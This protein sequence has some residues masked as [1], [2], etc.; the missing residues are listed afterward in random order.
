MKILRTI[1]TLC[2]AALLFSGCQDEEMIKQSGVKEGIPVTIDLTFS[3][4]IPEQEH[5]GTRTIT[6]PE[7][8]VNDLYVLIFN[9]NTGVLKGNV[10]S[11]DFTELGDG[12]KEIQ[13]DG[14]T[15]LQGTLSQIKTTTGESVIYAI[16]NVNNPP[17]EYNIT[18][19]V[20][21][22]ITNVQT[23][24]DLEKIVVKLRD[25]NA[26]AVDRIYETRY[27]MS[28]SLA[29]NIDENGIS[30]SD[31]DIPLLRTDSYITF[32]IDNKVEGTK[33]TSF[34]LLS[35]RIYNIPVGTS[36][37]SLDDKNY[38]DGVSD[39][40]ANYWNFVEAEQTGGNTF[41]FYLPEN[42]KQAKESFTDYASRD[43][44]NKNSDGTNGSFKYAPDY[45]T[46]VVLHGIYEGTASTTQ[47]IP[48]VENEENA[49]V[50]ASVDYI[51]HLGNF[52][53]YVTDFS[54]KRN[55]HYTYTIHV[56]GVDD[57]VVEVETSGDENPQEPEPGAEGDVFFR[58]GIFYNLDCH[59]E[60]VLMEFTAQEIQNVGAQADKYIQY[61]IS[62]PFGDKEDKH[63]LH[64]VLNKRAG[65]LMP[66][67][68]DEACKFADEAEN[69]IYTTNSVTVMSLDG[70]MTALNDILIKNS[71]SDYANNSGGIS[72]TCFVNEYVYDDKSWAEYV[73]Q[74][75]REAYIFGRV[76]YSK[77]QNSST[78][79][80]K[81]TISQRSIKTPDA[82]Y[83][84]GI[85]LGIETVN[86]TGDL[87]MGNPLSRSGS[88]PDSDED[89][90]QNTLSMFGTQ[91]WWSNNAVDVSNIPWG[92]IAPG[93]G[94]NYQTMGTDYEYAAYACLMRNR[95]EDG[96]GKIDE[97]EVKWYLPALDQYAAIYA[98]ST[99]LATE[100]QLYTQWDVVEKT[101]Y[102][103]S[104]WGN[105][106]EDAQTVK[107]PWIIWA[108]EGYNTQVLPNADSDYDN[109]DRQDYLTKRARPYRCI[110]NLSDR[111]TDRRTGFYSYN[112]DTRIIT[113]NHQQDY[114]G[115][116]AGSALSAHD[117]R[118]P[119][120]RF[121]TKFKVANDYLPQTYTTREA[122]VGNRCSSYSE[123][124]DNGKWRMPNQRELMA[125]YAAGVFDDLA[126]KSPNDDSGNRFVHCQT[127]YSFYDN[128]VNS[129]YGYGVQRTTDGNTVLLLI[130][131]LDQ[132]GY[133][134]CVRDFVE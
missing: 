4:V 31:K 98:G 87:P 125:M 72:V 82:Y 100:A 78:I 22:A 133:I 93:L 51:I 46:Y 75:N 5:V 53:K 89:G 94:N 41:N 10:L 64:F 118:E 63:W 126:D 20:K 88:Y 66:Y 129:K 55:V 39:K 43:L 23:I 25:R 2:A 95:D 36:L 18:D 48:G 99:A 112:S 124:G 15:T 111:G 80:T 26:N 60:P 7:Y 85:G 37:V 14:E 27:I 16:A 92:H 19:E 34:N 127:T 84:D 59:N 21:T 44:C 38:D 1:Y 96:N 69:G 123:N 106:E 65:T 76:T 56:K 52:G 131:E 103:S 3:A 97:S 91:A 9:E 11:Y 128:Q 110:R 90:L 49:E 45:G 33:C 108:E 58:T 101:H 119:E 40:S 120:N 67:P 81:Y 132:Q 30:G 113:I 6:D 17:S 71:N 105:R 8:R 83:E 13:Q 134:R 77:D 61:W 114:R 42:V 54:N 24:D 74:S 57:I 86:E 70:L 73:N 107:G 68:G 79:L 117:Q 130:R 28:G 50:R 115:Y 47:D 121:Y 62:S 12:Q 35:Y 122:R 102:L 29:C 104:T 116:D 109:D 32:I